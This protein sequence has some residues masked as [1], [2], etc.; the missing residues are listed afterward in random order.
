[1]RLT[2]NPILHTHVTLGR[3]HGY[4]FVLIAAAVAALGFGWIYANELA[5]QARY[6]HS[7]YAYRSLGTGAYAGL[8]MLQ[9]IVAALGALMVARGIAQHRSSGL[10]DANRLTPM[11]PHDLSAGYWLGPLLGPLALI[12]IGSAFG[13]YVAAAT[14]GVS[15]GAV[16]QSQAV[17]LSSTLVVG[18]AAAWLASE[19]PNPSS[20]SP[21]VIGACLAAPFGL[22]FG[23]RFVGNF[24]FGFPAHFQG[25]A[26]TRGRHLW[27][28][29][30]LFGM[31][32]DPVLLSLVLQA[33][34][35]ALAWRALVRKMARPNERSVRPPA[36]ITAVVVLIAVQHVLVADLWHERFAQSEW[37]RIDELV[38]GVYVVGTLGALI[39]AASMALGHQHVRRAVLRDGV[40]P[41]ALLRRSGVV[42]GAI[43]T[44]IAG[45]GWAMHPATSPSSVA[46]GAVDVFVSVVAL[47]AAIEAVRL[48]GTRKAGVLVAL[49]IGAAFFV[50]IFLGVLIDDD[51]AAT[52][53]GATGLIAIQ[54]GFS[55][56]NWH[57]DLVLAGVVLHSALAV[58][59]LRAWYGEFNRTIAAVRSTST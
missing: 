14:P 49:A 45:A 8:L 27:D 20:A 40:T 39:A 42:T 53:L 22:G 21:I 6:D 56:R 30:S 7:E 31:E 51:I 23:E 34:L 18:L 55:D 47:A 10:L 25:L 44:L 17:V 50:P 33:G 9:G 59:A 13:L 28:A 1:M 19:V 57:D 58:V 15:V 3:R 29:P 24:L 43:V 2:D 54:S 12:L 5:D 35:V 41:A 37:W 4:Q 48:R 11:T 52:T 46:L 36:V 26:S 38:G 32:L 16:L